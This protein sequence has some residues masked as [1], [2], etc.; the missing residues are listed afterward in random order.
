MDEWK[1]GREVFPPMIPDAGGMFENGKKSLGPPVVPFQ[2]RKVMVGPL[3]GVLLDRMQVV[4]FDGDAFQA[5]ETIF[6]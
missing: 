3:V 2:L 5:G 6:K 1:N 4:S